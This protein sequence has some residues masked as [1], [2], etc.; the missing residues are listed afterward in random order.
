MMSDPRLLGY[1]RVTL[2]YGAVL[3]LVWAI[4]A[5][6]PAML[7]HL[8]IGGVDDMSG[9]GGHL[10]H[11]LS[12]R[13]EIRDQVT[14]EITRTIAQDN[15]TEVQDLILALIGTVILMLPLVWTY[16]M[17]RSRCD[18]DR[19]LIETVLLLPIIVA[20]IVLIVQHSLALA[21]SL[22]GIVAGVQFRRG[23]QATSD[24]LYIF[25][26]IAVG[27]AAGVKA[28]EVAA[29]ISVFFNY[30]ALTSFASGYGSCEVTSRN[31]QKSGNDT[32]QSSLTL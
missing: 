31:S 19:A 4:L 20:G 7:F 9:P 28:L 11:S 24:S 27:L 26:A 17:T 2:Y 21:F 12:A 15:F 23:L 6:S 25:V 30:A 18:F 13:D 32:G 14:D 1:V 3:A 5:L 16:K 10:G 22:A 8:P 29:V